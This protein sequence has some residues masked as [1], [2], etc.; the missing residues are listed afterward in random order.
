MRYDVTIEVKQLDGSPFIEK[1]PDGDLVVTTGI[2]AL[3]AALSQPQQP[4]ADVKVKL[5]NTALRIQAAIE[6]DGIVDIKLEESNLLRAAAVGPFNTLA[7]G[8]LNDWLEDPI[9]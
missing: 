7:Y 3:R 2:L 5:Y 6:G 1:T 4:T 9:T 8:R